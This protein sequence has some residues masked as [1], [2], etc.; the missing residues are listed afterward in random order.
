MT[1]KEMISNEFI[2]RFYVWLDDYANM[3]DRE[4]A[5]KYGWHKS[6]KKYGDS[7]ASVMYFQSRIY[8]GRTTINSASAG[9]DLD[10]LR[11]LSKVGFLSTQQ[12]KWV[13]NYYISQRT[14]KQIY[15]E[16]KE[17]E[18]QK[19]KSYLEKR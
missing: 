6:S 12:R 9:Y 2:A 11:E 15:M 1:A 14:A 8:D 10:E 3:E 7:L 16:H 19:A 13:I 5:R 17:Q 4:Y 18:R